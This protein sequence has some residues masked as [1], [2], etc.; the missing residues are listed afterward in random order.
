MYIIYP[1]NT[2]LDAFRTNSRKVH[3]HIPL[4]ANQELRP[5]MR[6]AKLLFINCIQEGCLKFLRSREVDVDVCKLNNVIYSNTLKYHA[7]WV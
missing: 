3:G 4:L 6:V 2:L 5:M 1:Q 7:K